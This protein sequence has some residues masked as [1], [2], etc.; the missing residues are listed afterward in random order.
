MAKSKAEALIVTC[1]DFRLQSSINKWI[2]ENLNPDTFDRVALGGG[3][4]N[5][6]VILQQ[7]KIGNDLHQIKKVILVNH[8]NCGAYGEESNL[9]NHIADLKSAKH[10][11]NKL[12]PDLEVETYYLYLNGEFE[13][14][15]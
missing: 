6:D 4:K 15:I 3:V 2:S 11:I 12:Y 7:V 8:E 1:I 9:K 13:K 14:I 5:L 10:Q